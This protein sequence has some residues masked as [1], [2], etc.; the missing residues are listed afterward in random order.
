MKTG[1]ETFNRSLSNVLTWI[2]TV[3]LGVFVLTI[4]LGVFCRYVLNAPLV[5][6][7]ELA[8]NL[9]IWS[10]F[11]GASVALYKVD[12]LRVDIMDRSVARWPKIGQAVLSLLLIGA[13]ALF[14]LSLVLGG[15]HMTLDRWEVPLTTLPINQGWIYLAAPVSAMIMLWFLLWQAWG[16]VSGVIQKGGKA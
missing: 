10:V 6:S 4:I 7:E 3:L 15:W 9:N 13:E 1:I 2:A 11:L 8:R 16:T 12:H 14:A 5:W